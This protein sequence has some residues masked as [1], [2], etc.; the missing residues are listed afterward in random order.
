M[1][2]PENLLIEEM[3]INFAAST[4]YRYRMAV[5]IS[6]RNKPS[7]AHAG[8]NC[9]DPKANNGFSVKHPGPRRKR[10][11]RSGNSIKNSRIIPQFGQLRLFEIQPIEVL[12]LKLGDCLAGCGAEDGKIDHQNTLKSVFA[13]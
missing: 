5:N 9:P 8:E 4:A 1:D 3:L 13:L 12:R 2:P 11:S 7:L 6:P 10:I